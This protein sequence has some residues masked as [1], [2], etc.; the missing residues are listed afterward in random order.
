MTAAGA[1]RRTIALAC[2][3]A[4]AVGLGLALDT[5]PRAVAAL[6]IASALL[7][8][9]LYGVGKPTVV[10]AVATATLAFVPVYASPLLHN[11]TPN[12]SALLLWLTA[13]AEVLRQG[14]WPRALRANPIDIAVGLFFATM[15]IPVFASVRSVNDIGTPLFLWVG[16]YL[17]ARLVLSSE[18]RV[19][20]LLKLLAVVATVSIPLILWEAASGSNPFTHLDIN[21]QES[22]W[23]HPQVRLGATRVAGAFGHPLALSMFLVTASLICVALWLRAST[24]SERKRWLVAGVAIFGAQL[25]TLSRT[26]WIMAAAGIALFAIIHFGRDSRRRL[27]GA[28]AITGAVLVAALA[29]LPAERAVVTSISESGSGQLSENATYRTSLASQALRPGVLKLAGNRQSPFVEQTLTRFGYY[30]AQSASIDNNYIYLANQYGLIV[31]AAFVA[32][33]ATVA[34]LFVKQ[35]HSPL[36]VLP[37][38]VLANLVALYFLSFITQ[39]QILFWLLVGACGAFAQIASRTTPGGEPSLMRS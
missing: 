8:F 6:L 16:P 29:V 21:S 22:I 36:A 27:A 13:L 30:Q 1:I 7:V 4:L 11:F 18:E 19:Y 23:A 24:P 14:G 32:V 15:L 31:L 34:R 26:G 33:V 28:L 37:A 38:L 17:A 9:V 5:N 10:F 3:A 12:I 25:L 39:Q 35:V 20:S 2:L